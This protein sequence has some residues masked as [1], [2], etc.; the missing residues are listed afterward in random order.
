M[1]PDSSIHWNA[2]PAALMA[3]CLAA[4]IALAERIDL[5]PLLP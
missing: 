2:Y 4:G 1:R 5:T 3:G